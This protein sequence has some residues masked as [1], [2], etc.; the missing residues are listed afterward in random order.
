MHFK[1]QGFAE[2]ILLRVSWKGVLDVYLTIETAFDTTRASGMLFTCQL[3]PS[4]RVLRS[5]H[6]RFASLPFLAIFFPGD[7][8]A[9]S[10]PSER[11]RGSVTALLHFRRHMLECQ[12][13]EPIGSE[14]GRSR[15]LAIRS[16]GPDRKNVYIY[17]TLL[18]C[19]H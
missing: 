10:T 5:G 14:F 7:I 3:K 12:N 19:S 13:Q 16:P 1:A 4:E 8:L 9:L 2:I 15:E 11:T 6:F 18:S 17:L